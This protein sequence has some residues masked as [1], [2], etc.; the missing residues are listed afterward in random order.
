MLYEP[1]DERRAGFDEL[2]VQMRITNAI[3]AAMLQREHDLT[4][5][6][7]ITLLADAGTPPAEIAAALGTSVNTVR[8]SLSKNRKHTKKE[9]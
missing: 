6:E 7:V 2:L 8:V 3:L 1:R 5:K 9:G 4:Q